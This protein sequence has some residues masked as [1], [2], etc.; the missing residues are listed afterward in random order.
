MQGRDTMTRYLLAVLVTGL[1]AGV[2]YA[3]SEQYKAARLDSAI[4]QV[5]SGT[6]PDTAQMTDRSGRCH[7]IYCDSAGVWYQSGEPADSGRANWTPAIALCRVAA[8]NPTMLLF[9]DSPS[10]DGRLFVIWKRVSDGAIRCRRKWLLQPV[11]QWS[12]LLDLTPVPGSGAAP[13]AHPVR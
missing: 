9:Q 8:T 10:E 6:L 12:A 2:S 3:E 13:G 5:E 4:V 11:W 1:A 7:R